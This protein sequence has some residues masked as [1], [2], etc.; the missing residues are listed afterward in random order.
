VDEESLRFGRQVSWAIL[1]AVLGRAVTLLASCHERA[2]PCPTSAPKP[3]RQ[4]LEPTMMMLSKK[5]GWH[6]FHQLGGFPWS[7]AKLD[8]G[9]ILLLRSA[10]QRFPE[11]PWYVKLNHFCHNC[12]SS[13]RVSIGLQE[14][15]HILETE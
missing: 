4:A 9:S 1:A 6:G 5:L 7:H 15:C 13:L 8:D 14:T 3:S 2:A 11:G 10:F 12:S